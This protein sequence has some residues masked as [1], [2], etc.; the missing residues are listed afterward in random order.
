MTTAYPQTNPVAPVSTNCM[1]KHGSYFTITALGTNRQNCQSQ[2]EE[3]GKLSGYEILW[4]RKGGG[5]ISINLD[6][7]S[8]HEQTVYFLRPGQLRSILLTPGTSGYRIALSSDL[9]NMS[10]TSSLLLSLQYRDLNSHLAIEIDNETGSEIAHVLSKL[11]KEF[12]GQGMLRSE[13]LH[14]LFKVYMLYLSRSFRDGDTVEAPSN[15]V[16]LVNR[17]MVLVSQ[18]FVTR[19]L[20]MDYASEL[21]VTRGYLNYVVKKVCGFSFVF[22]IDC[23]IRYK[24]IALHTA[25]Q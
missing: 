14:S 13:I 20:V 9:L 21:C 16:N 3:P 2:I 11:E 22:I 6:R 12:S 19:K 5:T 15:E 23:L 4:I 24:S 1:S 8:M 18:Q 10:G 7:F 17:F 25:V